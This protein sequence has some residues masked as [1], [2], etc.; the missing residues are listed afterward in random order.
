MGLLDGGIQSIFGSAFGALYLN[1]ALT[2]TVQT[3]DDEGGGTVTPSDQPCKV[4]VDACTETMRR[5][6]GYTINDV[7]LYVLQVGISGGPIDT[8][9]YVTPATGPHAGIRYRLVAPIAQDPAAAYWNAR[10]TPA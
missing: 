1:A 8:A 7:S 5:A 3:S 4:Q 2:R 6:P 9:C 10:G